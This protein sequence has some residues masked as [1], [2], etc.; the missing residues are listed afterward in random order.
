MKKTAK[1]V[2]KKKV[3]KKKVAKRTTRKRAGKRPSAEHVRRRAAAAH[4]AAHAAQSGLQ[5]SLL[6]LIDDYHDE[7]DALLRHLEGDGTRLAWIDRQ[8]ESVEIAMSDLLD[9]DRS[10]EAAE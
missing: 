10:A 6:Q 7:L 5:T 9:L 4:A 3:A 8:R 1:K 2:A